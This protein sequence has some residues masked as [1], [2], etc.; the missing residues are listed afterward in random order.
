VA[1][2][3]TV[4]LRAGRDELDK[5]R[6]LDVAEQ[7]EQAFRQAG[8]A[9]IDINDPRR[10]WNQ[11]LVTVPEAPKLGPVMAEIQRA[12]RDHRLDDIARVKR[13]RLVDP[14]PSPAPRPR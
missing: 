7:L 3:I 10:K 11:L 5:S 12:L 14:A 6:V 4:E 1:Y 8:V 9:G 2:L 13:R